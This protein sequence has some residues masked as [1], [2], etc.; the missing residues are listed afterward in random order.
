ML[1][2]L[3]SLIGENAINLNKM[4][5]MLT[6]QSGTVTIDDYPYHPRPRESF[7]K[8]KIYNIIKDSV[9][10]NEYHI[11]CILAQFVKLKDKLNAI[12]FDRQNNTDPFWN[13]GAI[14]HIDGAMLYTTIATKNPRYY[15]ECGS[16][17]TTK[18]AARA[19]REQS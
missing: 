5:D 16:G 2:K 13:N 6:Q 17:N 19:I 8:S 4:K 1:D 7:S 12:S 9:Y 3:L 15:V 11:K 14:P 18:F 10:K